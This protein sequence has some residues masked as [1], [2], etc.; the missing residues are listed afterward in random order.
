MKIAIIGYSGSG[1]ST[2]AKRLADDIGIR[3]LYLDCVHFMPGWSERE[4]EESR[5][6]VRRELQKKDWVIDGN[7]RL[8]LREERLKDADEIVFLNYPRI[9]CLMRALGRHSE[10]RNKTRE[11]AAGGCI[12]KM[13]F[14]FIWWI[15]YKGRTREKRSGYKNVMS[16][17][18]DKTVEIRND[19]AMRRYL[20]Q[21][22]KRGVQA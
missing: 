2:L 5:D 15:L 21:R 13:D 18:P 4:T 20:Q 16:R 3:P 14:E 1:K 8:L 19:R 9:V 6:V 22:A 10:F 7:Y 17:Y 12:E 11:S